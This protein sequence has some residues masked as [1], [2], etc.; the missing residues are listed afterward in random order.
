MFFACLTLL[1]GSIAP[2]YADHAP[3]TAAGLWS[4][5]D[6]TQRKAWVLIIERRGLF[7]AFVVKTFPAFGGPGS[8][9]IARPLI[10]GLKRR[11]S[12]YTDGRF[13]DPRDGKENEA[14][15][16]LST[17]GD[18]LTIV[19]AAQN[20]IDG[21]DRFYRLQDEWLR[22][23]PHPPARLS[24][25]NRQAFQDAKSKALAMTET[26]IIDALTPPRLTS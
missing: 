10:E 19:D 17:N 1:L 16:E 9:E 6:G 26:S 2:A 15:L 21:R 8:D 18:M 13:S 5:D 22:N 20:P 4:W 3:K 7:D 12:H 11:D 24:P 14:Y 23:V 25:E